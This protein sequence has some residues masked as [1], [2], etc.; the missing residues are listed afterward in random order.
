MEFDMMFRKLCMPALGSIA[1]FHP[2]N[3]TEY[4]TA[5][6]GRAGHS[7]EADGTAWLISRY[8]PLGVDL[9]QVAVGVLM[10]EILTAPVFIYIARVNNT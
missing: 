9:R 5:T 7:W 2:F 1:L 6:L 3:D 10:V 4:L 8:A